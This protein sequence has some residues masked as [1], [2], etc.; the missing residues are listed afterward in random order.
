M[1]RNPR[2]GVTL[3]E[4]LVAIFVCGLGMM[5][6]MTLFPLGA[7]NMAQALKD[8]RCGHC[9]G[10]AA[11]IL[12]SFWRASLEG[13][14][15]V[16]DPTD[17]SRTKLIDDPQLMALEN[18]LRSSP[19]YIDPLGFN[20]YGGQALPGGI[21]RRNLGNCSFQQA[22]RWCTFLDD[23]DFNPNG[24]PVNLGSEISRQGRFSWAWMVRWMGKPTHPDPRA[25]ALEFQ[26]VVYANRPQTQSLSQVPIGENAYPA[27]FDPVNNIIVVPGTPSIKKGHWI[28][29]ASTPNQVPL[30]YFYRVISVKNAGGSLILTTQQAFRGW[31]AP[32]QG[33][34]VHMENVA[35]VFERSTLE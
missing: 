14:S 31:T 9:A 25:R 18:D 15:R 27:S 17:P 35:E 29:D 11:A 24:L 16:L 1:H 12:R 32:G 22:L 4:C 10:N 2:P 6:L 8:D 5:A 30:G 28:L 13:G 33:T 34:I 20:L 26:V 21:P 3:T 7:M 23:L 19:V